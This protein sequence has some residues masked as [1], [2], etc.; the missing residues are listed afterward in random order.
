[1]LVRKAITGLLFMG[2]TFLLNAQD[3][4]VNNYEKEKALK[5][6][7]A[8]IESYNKIFTP[9][10]LINNKRSEFSISNE[11]TGRKIEY[12]PNTPINI[13]VGLTYKWIGI[14]LAFNL[15]F[16]NNDN[17]TYG[18]TKRFDA[19]AN[20][21]AR[22]FNIDFIFQN[23]RGY[24]VSNPVIV[25]PGWQPGDP[26]PIRS[27]VNSAAFGFNLNY[28]FNNRK[29][30]YKAAFNFNERQKKSS[31]TALAGGGF[32]TYVIN[33]DTNLIPPA[34]FP[35]TVTPVKL[36][37]IR[38]ST[39]YT[40]GGYAYMFIIRNWYFMLSLNLGVGLSSSRGRFQDEL[41]T[42]NDKFSFITDY[43]GSVGYNA[44]KYYIGLSWFSG[45]FSIYS[46]ED[47]RVRYSLSRISLYLG[48]RFFPKKDK[49]KKN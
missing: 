48:Y 42:E 26:Y 9:R 16:I 40:M 12:R 2:L 5:Y 39:V 3:N 35:D 45:A 24:Y 14:N 37:R 49:Q 19:Q 25:D 6:D 18:K 23:Y 22:K 13:G 47:I 31:G 27:D 36:D 10:F 15:P 1:M 44:E 46:T 29:F 30:S 20:I 21:Y 17:N 7:T 33:S 43:K 28:I 38:L 4:D 34:A 32:L 11:L 8:Y 41:V